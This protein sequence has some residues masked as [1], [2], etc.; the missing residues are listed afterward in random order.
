VLC[1]VGEAA[2][3]LA[4]HINAEVCGYINVPRVAMRTG[5]GRASSALETR[6]TS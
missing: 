3:T 1:L 6:D 5:I 2:L 4:G